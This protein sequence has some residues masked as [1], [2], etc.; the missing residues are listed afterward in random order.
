MATLTMTRTPTLTELRGE[1]DAHEI[2]NRF[3]VPFNI[4]DILDWRIGRFQ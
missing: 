4:R 2:P 3:I 1:Q